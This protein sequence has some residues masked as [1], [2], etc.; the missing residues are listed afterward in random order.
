[1]AESVRHSPP[2]A[3]LLRQ[4]DVALGY[5]PGTTRTGTDQSWHAA[6][7]PEGGVA[8]NKPKRRPI[9]GLALHVMT[10]L[11]SGVAINRICDRWNLR[12]GQV[13]AIRRYLF[14]MTRLTV[15]ELQE[16]LR[17]VRKRRIAEAVLQIRDA[18]FCEL[19]AAFE[20]E[21]SNHEPT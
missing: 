20:F 18:R 16:R 4:N 3:L 14:H 6:G 5:L 15:P 2:H 8:V 10:E 7:R 12:R 9:G 21:R 13:L 19:K 17:G 1:M 11:V